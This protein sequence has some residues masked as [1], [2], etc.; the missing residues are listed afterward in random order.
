[1][2]LILQGII[3]SLI[4]QQNRQLGALKNN[5]SVHCPF[6]LMLSLP[7]IKDTPS[8]K[9][10]KPYSLFISKLLAIYWQ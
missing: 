2:K 7:T 9:P 3:K 4:I 1:M 6:E 5:Q 8:K 10:S